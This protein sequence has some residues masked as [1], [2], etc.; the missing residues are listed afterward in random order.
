MTRITPYH[1]PVECR[2]YVEDYTT[3]DRVKHQTH[4]LAVMSEICNSLQQG[5]FA[6]P[7]GREELFGRL[8]PYSVYA[9][10]HMLDEME[11]YVSGTG[12][13]VKGNPMFRQL[14]PYTVLAR[15]EDNQFQVYAYQ[16]GKYVAERDESGD[17]IGEQRLAGKVSIGWGGHI[18]MSPNIKVIPS[19]GSM[20]NIGEAI[21]EGAQRE[22]REE[23]KV[24]Y[25]SS[26]SR[27][28]PLHASREEPLTTL[29]INSDATEVDRLHFGIV[30]VL[31]L[32][33]DQHDL[34]PAERALQ[35]LGWIN[36]TQLEQEDCESWTAQLIPELKKLAERTVRDIEAG[37]RVPGYNPNPNYKASEPHS[38][39]VTD[40]TWH[41]VAVDNFTEEEIAEDKAIR[42]EAAK[43]YE[44]ATPASSRSESSDSSYDSGSSSS[45]SSSFD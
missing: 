26:G 32:R 12:E 38:P 23:L 11:H 33:Q 31:L 40:I 21:H 36:L 29:F 9:S 44:P 37:L 8:A 39:T 1:A 5:V 15:I 3:L 18:D 27:W 6:Y 42:E 17:T 34:H 35:P 14:L 30:D 22:L 41:A 45:S 13:I 20:F 7:T 2:E 43:A 24:H 25:N 4:I 28:L 16:R 19:S 10:R